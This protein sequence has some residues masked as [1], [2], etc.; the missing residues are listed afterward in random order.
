MLMI[1]RVDTGV[2]FSAP[3]VRIF[4]R[5]HAV[6]VQDAGQFDL[7]LDR[8]VLVQDPVYAVLVV[9]GGEDVRDDEFAGACDHDAV[10]AEIGVFE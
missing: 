1:M 3:S 5:V 10:V 8:A 4:A 6:R 9:G 2:H 7:E